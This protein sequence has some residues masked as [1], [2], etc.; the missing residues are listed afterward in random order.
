MRYRYR[1]LYIVRSFALLALLLLLPGQSN[2]Q[3]MQGMQGET[4]TYTAFDQLEYTRVDAE[5]V[6]RW[7]LTGWSGGDYNR[8]WVK[9]EGDIGIADQ[10]GEGEVQVLYSRLVASFWEAQIGLRFDALRAGDKT[11]G[12]ALLAVGLNG[13]APYWF[14]VEP[15]LFISDKGDLSAR[16]SAVYDLRVT[17]RLI[18]Q[19]RIE[20]NAAV[21]SVP[22]FAIAEGINDLQLDLRLQYE[23]KREFAPYVGVSWVRKFGKTADIASLSQTDRSSAVLVAGIRCWR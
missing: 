4:F 13:L 2:G 7:E 5:N 1:D 14:E 19:P 3:G 17:Q 11:D 23:F 10:D 18:V 12:R 20:V 16:L 6:L 9:S 22:E 8:L 15:A 21:Q